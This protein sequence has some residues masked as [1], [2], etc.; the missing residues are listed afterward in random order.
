[1]ENLIAFN[2]ELLVEDLQVANYYNFKKQRK[3][4]FNQLIFIG[5]AILMIIMA[6]SQKQWVFLGVGIVLL[7]FS[8]VFFLPLYKIM[9]YKA[10]KKNMQE[11]LKIKIA[12]D[13][14][15]FTYALTE[16]PDE[17][18]AKYTYDQV[19][20]VVV[21]PEYIYLYFTGAM[22]AIIKKSDCEQIEELEKLVEEK[23]KEAG[24]YE[25]I[26]KMPR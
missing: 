8:T 7:I 9:I 3:Y 24:K 13:E 20:K 16:T 15:G 1:M 4:L 2:E 11:S 14:E 17:E 5:M 10:V 22:I 19:L 6:S 21:L 18:V 25:K 23:Y 12:F 26:N